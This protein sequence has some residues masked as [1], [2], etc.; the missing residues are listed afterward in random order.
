MQGLFRIAT[1]DTVAGGVAMPAG[2]FVW[3]VY[4]SATA[5]RIN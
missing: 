5:T 3:L 2:T 4:G 1:C